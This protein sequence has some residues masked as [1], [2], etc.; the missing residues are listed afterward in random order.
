[1]SRAFARLFLYIPDMPRGTV[2]LIDGLMLT[3]RP[4]PLL[5]PDTGGIW[6]LDLPPKF[7]SLIGRRVRVEGIRFGFDMLDVRS[8][9]AL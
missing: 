6:R 1:M 8:V 2:H 3:G 5:R 9:T 4:Y 7:H